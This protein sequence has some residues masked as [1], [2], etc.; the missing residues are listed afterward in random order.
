MEPFEIPIA[1]FELIGHEI[2][3]RNHLRILVPDEPGPGGM[4]HRY[5]IYGRNEGASTAFCAGEINFQKGG[6]AEAGV[7]GVTVEALLRI[8]AHRLECAQKGPFPCD[9][10]EDAL[11]HIAQ[12]LTALL[13]RTRAR[14]ARGVEGRS[15]A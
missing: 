11:T 7:N 10:N 3:G 13:N 5:C 12:A 2:E 6:V 1:A 9:E 14:A 15:V 4:H 8:C